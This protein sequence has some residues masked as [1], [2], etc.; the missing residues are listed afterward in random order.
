MNGPS[1][2]QKRSVFT[3]LPWEVWVYIGLVITTGLGYAIYTRNAW[4]DFFITFRHSENLAHGHGLVYQIGE[5]VHGFTSVI[6]TLLPAVFSAFVEPGNWLFPLWGYRIVSLLG[7]LTGGAVLLTYLHR[8][9]LA[10]TPVLLCI[11]VLMA[12][13]AKTVAYTM[14]GQEA[15]FLALFILPSMVLLDAGFRRHF[16]WAGVCWA[17]L[18]YTRPDGCIYIALMGILALLF[19]RP[20]WKEEFLGLLKAGAVC[21]IL[22]LPWFIFAWVYYGN[23]IPNTILAKLNYDDHVYSLWGQLK[24]TATSIVEFAGRSFMPIYSDNGGWP[25]PYYIFFRT[26]GVCCALY[27]AVPRAPRFGRICSAFYGLGLVY[28]TFQTATTPW[29]YPVFAIV[30][31]VALGFLVFDLA[32]R[33]VPAA[34]EGQRALALAPIFAVF[35][36]FVFA[37]QFIEQARTIRMQQ[38]MNE[39]SVRMKIGKFLRENVRPGDRVFLECLGYIGYFSGAKMTDFPGLA[40]KEVVA[41]MSKNG[42]SFEGTARELRP[43]WMVLRGFEFNL[44]RYSEFFQKEYQPVRGFEAPVAIKDL[45]VHGE[46]YLAADRSF[47]IFKR[48]DTKLRGEDTPVES[49]TAAATENP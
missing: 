41:I 33:I 38:F 7:L 15:G 19:H 39:Y 3:R 21:A 16:I 20:Q 6:N 18:L 42:G 28:L 22:Y 26:V 27:W 25:T 45:G 46:W 35:V 36:A 44:L 4:E 12:L 23:P 31:V 10:K 24:D 37:I 11:G 1:L 13:E 8:K 49:A 29:Y 40:S 9:G 34:R 30:G 48:V 47:M 43:E 2:T 5:R 17:G 14:N 32:G